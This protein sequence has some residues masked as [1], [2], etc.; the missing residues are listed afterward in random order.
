VLGSDFTASP[1]RR[2]AML[3]GVILGALA[4]SVV[5]PQGGI[6]FISVGVV[7]MRSGDLLW[8]DTRQGQAAD[9]RNEADVRRML[10]QIFG[11]YPGKPAAATPARG[12]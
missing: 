10:D 2:A 11:T 4:G 6:A 3:M 7:D 1:A 8:F 12:A 9:L 5:I